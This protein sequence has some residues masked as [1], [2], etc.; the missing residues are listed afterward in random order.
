MVS[1]LRD[2]PAHALNGGILAARCRLQTLAT[3]KSPR[4]GIAAARYGDQASLESAS[5]KLP[6]VTACA[7][8]LAWMVSAIA[9]GTMKRS[10]L[11]LVNIRKAIELPSGDQTGWEMTPDWIS[12]ALSL[13]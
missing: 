8:P 5:R 13:G 10:K 12:T 4:V 6:W 3:R 1:P 11:P 9:T 2:V 7:G